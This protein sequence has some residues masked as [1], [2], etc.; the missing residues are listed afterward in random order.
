[1]K[2]FHAARARL[3][4]LARRSAESRIDHE[5]GFHI[6]METDRLTREERL[7]PDE[8]RR[9]ALATFG[10]VQQHRETLREGRG[11]S[12]L[13][14]FSL[15]L[16]LGFRMLVKY[17]GLTAIGGL[18]MAFGIWFGAVSFELLGTLAYPELTLPDGD[19]IVQIRNWDVKESDDDPRALY[20]FLA[21]RESAKSVTDIGAYRDVTV[22]LVGADRNAYPVVAAEITTSAFRIAPAR[23]V[24]GRVLD[25]TDEQPGAAPVAVI[26]FD[27]WKTRLNGDPQIIGR[28]VQLGNTFATVVGVMPEG[29]GFPV[30]H[31][32]W[33]PLHTESFEKAPR[34]GPPITVFGRLAPGLSI[35]MAQSEFTTIGQRT[36]SEFPVTHGDLTPR[37]RPYAKSFVD[38]NSSD[39]GFM[40]LIE[41]FVVLL[42][43]VV[44]GNVAL[45]L[46]AR[47]ASRETEIIVRS[48]L[49]A[50]RR[51]IVAQLFAEALVLGTAAAV[52]GLAAARI[53]L[54]RLG[55]PYLEHNFGRLPFW[56]DIQLSWPTVVYAIGLTLLSAVIAGVIPARKIT[57]GLG[58]QLKTQTA[59]GGGVSFGGIWTGVIVMQ[60]ALTV[61]F[62][63][64]VMVIQNEIDR[65]SS[66]DAG[67]AM[68]EYV[69]LQLEMDFPV[70][71]ES[72]MESAR[73]AMGARFT[74]A[75]ET[76]RQRLEA[77]PE[78]EAV[79]YAE[80]L[81][82]WYHREP[83]GEILSLPGNPVHEL[84]TAIVE[85]AYFD[86]LE[87]PLLSGRGFNASDLPPNGRAVIV[88]EG[89]VAAVMQGR[90][91]IGHRIRLDNGSN[92]TD[93]NDLPW[94]E[95]VG[96][97]KELGMAFALRTRR[98]AGVYLPGRP[99][100]MGQIYLIIHSRGDPFQAGHRAR[101]ILTSVDPLLR[102]SDMQRLDQVATPLLWDIELWSR[103]AI[104][105]TAVALLLSLAGIYAVLSF[106]VARRT[107]EIGVRVALGASRRLIVTQVFRKP[108][109]QVMLGVGAGSV[110]VGVG[111]WLLSNS[112]QFRGSPAAAFTLGDGAL[113]MVYAVFMFGVC[114]LACIVPTMR[115]LGVQPTEAL[116]AD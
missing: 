82:R 69:G 31:D 59:G 12:W 66:Y 9:R 104:G 87:T 116:R 68:H 79:T 88:D 5:I 16:K 62:P 10:G 63:S 47:A 89:F 81:P 102:I 115:A 70:V 72:E 44:C 55:G 22:N 46:F 56:Y 97:A 6:D 98:A 95:I 84:T 114:L 64:V 18:A 38:M 61:A 57:R 51:R 113:L 91:P 27:I 53:S 13:G 100:H 28:V 110:L 77:D 7:A 76:L 23:P 30:S 54:E 73:A 15:D 41:F 94:Y 11:T 17:P 34:G 75:M 109:R 101:S 3:R 14:G 33:M 29:Y 8:A 49:G 24:Q 37:L 67:F 74:T 43:C 19:R 25:A 103:I 4:L 42:L 85:P 35:E 90:N 108:L 112:E 52:V 26:S 60:V 1:M 106:T 50:S 99:A 86:V 45:L 58:S 36:S 71:A 65:I 96:V 2:W 107:R 78:V 80:A 48:A 40:V 21:W 20:D 93:R 92:V 83:L 39:F 111:A 105:L 32:V